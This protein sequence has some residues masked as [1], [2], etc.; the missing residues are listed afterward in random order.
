[1]KKIIL[2]VVFGLILST[3]LSYAALT[4]N[5]LQTKDAN[6][7]QRENSIA[8]REAVITQAQANISQNLQQRAQ[9][10]ITRRLVFLNDLI[11][12]INGIKKLSSAEK[13]DL[14]GQ[15]QTQIDG[16]NTLQ[17]KIKADTDN[18]TLRADVK[19][20]VTDYYIFL[21]FRV[22]VNLLVAADRL[23]TTTDNLSAIYTKL[24][25]RIN[26]EQTAGNDV[27]ALNSLLSDMNAKITDAQT[28]YTAVQTEL[29]PLTT[30]GY[31]GNKSTLQDARAKI[32]AAVQD[33]KA[34]YKDAL[35]IRDGLRGLKVKNPEASSSAVQS[36]H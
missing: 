24:Q 17:A 11:T 29:T 3:N 8:S 1:M 33:L 22:K 28:Q 26:Q 25:T 27:T 12:K 31:P 5:L 21:F 6:L 35:Q 7:A 34:A 32:Q 10:E 14:Q 30:Q 36:A 13:T 23:S 18:T 2:L 15:I 19:S 20:I 4:S 16:L 9:T